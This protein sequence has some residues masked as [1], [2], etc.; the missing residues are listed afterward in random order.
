MCSSCLEQMIQSSLRALVNEQLAENRCADFFLGLA[1]LWRS[2][3]RLLCANSAKKGNLAA[4][5]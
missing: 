2:A 4:H 3:N 1:P 5:G